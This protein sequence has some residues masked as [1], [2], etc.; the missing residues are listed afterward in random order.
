MYTISFGTAARTYG[1]RDGL[2]ETVRDH[3]RIPIFAT[4]FLIGYS[5]E[6]V[7]RSNLSGAR[8]IEIARRSRI[9]GATRVRLCTSVGDRADNERPKVR[10]DEHVW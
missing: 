4:V 10:S 2:P 3:Y 7:T 5:R 8:T 6:N 1:I 9:D